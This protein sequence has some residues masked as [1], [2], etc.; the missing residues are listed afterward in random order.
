M[1][2]RGA[3]RRT[4]VSWRS[5]L[6]YSSFDRHRGS[7]SLDNSLVGERRV[8][9]NGPNSHFKHSPSFNVW[10]VCPVSAGGVSGGTWRHDGN[11]LIVALSIV[12]VA[13]LW[14]VFVNIKTIP[15]SNIHDISLDSNK[16]ELKISHERK[17]NVRQWL[18]WSD[19]ELETT[20]RT[21][22]DLRE[23]QEILNLR[24]FSVESTAKAN[25]SVRK[26]KNSRANL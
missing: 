26:S 7:F 12:Y 11:R 3:F 24:G 4:K 2:S 22:D 20:P 10:T 25:S 17:G 21:A 1:N 14:M 6:A 15:L 8:R 18:G 13:I 9:G 23:A 16:G 19:A 5:A